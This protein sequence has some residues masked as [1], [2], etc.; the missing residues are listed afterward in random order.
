MENL[1]TSLESTGTGQAPL[2][3][4]W[5][6]ALCASSFRFLKREH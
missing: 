3:S 4:R 2:T 6:K 5:A 1:N